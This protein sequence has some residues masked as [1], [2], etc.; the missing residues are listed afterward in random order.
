MFTTYT[1]INGSTYMA[2][3]HWPPIQ[4]VEEAECRTAEKNNNESF[5]NA[6]YRNPTN[7]YGTYTRANCIHSKHLGAAWNSQR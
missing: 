1:V 6:D 4:F 7:G 3:H 5:K 2:P